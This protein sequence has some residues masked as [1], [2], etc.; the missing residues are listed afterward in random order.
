MAYW[1]DVESAMLER[2]ALETLASVESAPFL[3]G[4][5]A[6]TISDLVREIA[7]QAQFARDTD[8]PCAP[9]LEVDERVLPEMADYVEQRGDWLQTF[10]GSL[11]IH[12]LEGHLQQLRERV[13]GSLRAGG[14]PVEPGQL[15]YPL[16][17][18]A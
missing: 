4:E 12:P 13:I 11:G 8:Q 1:R 7:V 10:S 9:R 5:V 3:H 2:P 16:F 18:G 17:G 14:R 15:S 6:R